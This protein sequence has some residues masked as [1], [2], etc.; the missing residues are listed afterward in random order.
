MA[1][2]QYTIG[3][4]IGSHSIKL[5]QIKESKKGLSL[6]NFALSTLPNDAIYEG[7]IR[8]REAVK[9]AILKIFASHG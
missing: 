7:G 3:L 6:E 5:V 8:D 2:K 1:K 4:D 9:T